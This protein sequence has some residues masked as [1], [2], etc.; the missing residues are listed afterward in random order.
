MINTSQLINISQKKLQMEYQKQLILQ[1]RTKEDIKAAKPQEITNPPLAIN[2][3]IRNLQKQLNYKS[4]FNYYKLQRKYKQ[5]DHKSSK[6]IK[7]KQHDIQLSCCNLVTLQWSCCQNLC[8][9]DFDISNNSDVFR[10][11]ILLSSMYCKAYDIFQRSTNLYSRLLF[12][13]PFIKCLQMEIECIMFITSGQGDGRIKSKI[14]I[15]QIEIYTFD[16]NL[17]HRTNMGQ[18][19]YEQ[20]TCLL[21]Q[22]YQL[23]INQTNYSDVSLYKLQTENCQTKDN[24]KALTDKDQNIVKQYVIIESYK[25]KSFNIYN[26]I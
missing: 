18:T 4:Y 19:N 25:P 21:Y 26:N 1:Y 10:N 16:L 3:E 14:Y 12:V 20:Y 24:I 7:S 8:N 22:F 6:Q 23:I 2:P 13:G 15:Y 11:V 17:R 5:F 9:V